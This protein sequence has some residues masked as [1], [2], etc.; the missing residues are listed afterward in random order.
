MKKDM[1][2][3]IRHL[4]EAHEKIRDNYLDDSK[5]AFGHNTL[6]WDLAEKKSA[7]KVYLI[8]LGSYYYYY[9]MPTDCPPGKK[10]RRVL[11]KSRSQTHCYNTHKHFSDPLLQYTV[12]HIPKPVHI[13]QEQHEKVGSGLEKKR[14]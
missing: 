6:A 1:R 10:K 7:I 5:F 14:Q 12:S 13:P 8:L 9:Y 4:S 2:K 3:Q 11:K